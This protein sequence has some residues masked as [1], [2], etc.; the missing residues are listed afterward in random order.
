MRVALVAPY[1]ED[2]P[3]L[4][5]TQ[6]PPLGILYLAASIKDI[7]EDIM[8]LDA[9]F[10][11]LN[12][13]Q[14]YKRIKEFHPHVVGISINMTTEKSAKELAVCIR[15]NNP[16]IK[17]VTGGSSPTVAP[18]EWYG[19]FDVVTAGEGEIAFRNVI[20]QYLTKDSISC[21][22][23]GI[24]V[25]GKEATKACHP[26]I[27]NLP[28]PAYQYLV[29]PLACYSN[30]ARLVK[31]YMAPLL[32][33]RGCPYC[34]TFCD[35]SVHGI[36]FRPRT[37]E[38]VL[39]EIKWLHDEYGV[40]Q[41][42]I[43]D[44][45]FTFDL[46]RA[47][48]ILDGIIKMK[49]IRI[50]CQNG[51]RAD[52]VT[53]TLV[54]KMKKAGVLRVGIGIES[55]NESV[56]QRINKKLDLNKVEYAISLFRQHRITVHGFFIIG[57]PFESELDIKDTINFAIKANPHFA[58]FSRFMPIKGTALFDELL[59]K[60][61]L[62]EKQE[63]NFFSLTAPVKYDNITEERLNQLFHSIWRDFYL[64]PSKVFDI[65]KNIKSFK[66]FIWIIRLGISVL[67]RF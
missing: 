43:L 19:Y 40:H 58:N 25:D 5:T 49:N 10:L 38:S 46:T 17:L 26:D 16:N 1:A 30:K 18:E 41:F 42:D 8:V 13:E 45:N 64:R 44:D 56:L 28:F 59:S 47:E 35:K 32:T 48:K 61:L 15:K 55:G 29:P 57:F 37:P 9:S 52:R 50:T 12:V 54:Q 63:H 66:E 3:D 67:K 23:K 60:G 53:P 33:S 22:V 14:T 24:C 21:T 7:A 62:T 6:Y 31:K 65:L 34:C 4:S 2:L 36:N 39:Q 11:K 27:E 20:Q 51:L